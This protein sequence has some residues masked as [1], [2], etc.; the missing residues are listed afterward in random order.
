MAIGKSHTTNDSKMKKIL[1]ILLLNFNLAYCQMKEATIFFN[2]S[3]S[4][5]G[6]AEIKKNKILFKVEE[7]DE[8]SEWS[9][10]IAKAVVFSS[11]GYSEKYEYISFAT[12]KKPILLQVIEEGNVSLYLD[13]N[14]VT[15]FLYFGGINSVGFGNTMTNPYGISYATVPSSV[16]ADM[17]KVYYTKR[18]NEAIATNI[19]ANFSKK[20]LK[21]FEDCGVLVKK[22][23]TGKFR[24]DDIE[25]IISYYNN[26]CYED[27][28][29]D[30]TNR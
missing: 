21:Y 8:A 22:I 14:F 18:K 3:T 25:E 10:D 15:D 4:I 13:I 24:K 2:D 12:N 1:F 19:T 30:D 7:K 6:F 28:T 29:D 23:K 9:S 27:E 11:Y 20:S 16:N 26:Y 17:K 5:E